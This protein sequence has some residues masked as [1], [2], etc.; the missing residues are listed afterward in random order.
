MTKPNIFQISTKELSQDGF[1]T[2]L[3]QW[4]DDSNL[5]YDKE[6]SETAKNFV[7][8]LIEK[9]GEN[10][11][12]RIETV[13]TH[14][15]WKHIDIL[16]EINNEYVIAIEDK[17]D[18]GEHSNQLESYKENIEKENKYKDLKQVFIY[19]K[20]GNESLAKLERIKQ[21]KWKIIKRED[22]LNVLNSCKTQNNIFKDFKDHLN[23][24][25]EET[26]SFREFE[27]VKT[28]WKACEG[29]YLKLQ[30]LISEWS[31]WHYVPNPS[32]GFLYFG[33]YW[34]GCKDYEL[35]I[36]IENK[37]LKEIKLKIRVG[38]SLRFVEKNDFLK[39]NL[40]TE[41]IWTELIKNDW[42][43]NKG[44]IKVKFSDESKNLILEN[45]TEEQT[46]KIIEIFKKSKLKKLNIN[47]N[48]VFS[49]LKN[50]AQNKGIVLI[51][52]DGRNGGATASLAEVKYDFPE[53]GEFEFNKFLE[54]LKKVEEIICEYSKHNKISEGKND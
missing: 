13:E 4:A 10:S 28:N 44:I 2:W 32:G 47:L 45:F 27:N 30:E 42:I 15:Q 36:Q 19:L 34:Q 25:E 16:A 3:L 29:F 9:N 49:E 52:D 33:Y 43:D 14:R 41:I 38:S 22:V 23:H 8:L 31:D 46:S 39:L 21:K 54:I 35:Y 50:I 1:F 24:I 48:S 20:T 12:Y 37:I 53:K 40:D 26:K 6:L 17:I 11:D 18:T 51:K 5:E 7:R